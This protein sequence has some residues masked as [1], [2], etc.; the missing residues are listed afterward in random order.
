MACVLELAIMSA[1]AAEELA[2]LE[3]EL[4]P[5]I[6]AQHDRAFTDGVVRH[7]PGVRRLV[8]RLLG[9]PKTAVDVDDIVQ[10]VLLL[11]WRHRHRF[12][13]D[14]AW[15]TWLVHIGINTTR[16]HQRRRALWRRLFVEP[17]GSPHDESTEPV[18]PTAGVDLDEKLAP[19]RAA[20]ADLKHRD[21]ELLVLRYLEQ[22]SIEEIAV[23]LGARTRATSAGVAHPR[24][25]TAPTDRPHRAASARSS[26]YGRRARRA[27]A[28][29]RGPGGDARPSAASHRGPAA[30]AG[31][32]HA[33]PRRPLALRHSVAGGPPPLDRPS[34]RLTGRHAARP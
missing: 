1:R 19:V 14:A 21:R 7:E 31:R 34:T 30:C 24:R 15:G 27:R 33:S 11:A 10:E 2:H 8:H 23:D 25:P 26:Q 29:G 9:W 12:R 22:R 13:G 5:A 17:S 16:N 28:A 4:P 3:A 18:A 32:P 20:M 6:A